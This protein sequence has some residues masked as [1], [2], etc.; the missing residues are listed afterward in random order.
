MTSGTLS[1][2]LSK[3][4]FSKNFFKI[5][6]L[7]R[8]SQSESASNGELP[9]VSNGSW[10]YPL[11]RDESVQIY[12]YTG[13]IVGLFVASVVRTL[14]FFNICMQASVTLHKLMFSGVLRAPMKFF[15]TNPVGKSPSFLCAF[16]G[17]GSKVMAV[18]LG[19]WVIILSL[20]GLFY[21]RC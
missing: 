17:L 2:K 3:T 12:V 1:R 4:S 14:I 5:R 13:I 21:R 11:Y 8:T 15:E 18:I 6:F 16:H 20:L 19:H 7:P 10:W 9:P